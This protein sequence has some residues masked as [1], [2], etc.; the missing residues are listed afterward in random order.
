[1]TRIEKAII[2]HS[3]WMFVLTA[4]LAIAQVQTPM[5]STAPQETP[6]GASVVFSGET[7]FTVYDKVGSF[8]PQERA[9][10]IA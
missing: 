7:L 4:S 3:L 10:A 1:M 2:V 8:G 5:I 6:A 9:M